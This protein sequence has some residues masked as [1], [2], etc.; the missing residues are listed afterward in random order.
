MSGNFGGFR[1]SGRST[2]VRVC[3]APS[4]NS[5]GF[6]AL[7]TFP[8]MGFRE[9]PLLATHGGKSDKGVAGASP[10]TSAMHVTRTS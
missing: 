7:L 5:A 3:I 9:K 6:A 4:A 1:S 8:G 10:A 2:A